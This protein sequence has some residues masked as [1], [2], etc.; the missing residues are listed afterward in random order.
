MDD[1][2]KKVCSEILNPENKEE[3]K[4]TIVEENLSQ[5]SG[6]KSNQGEDQEILINSENFKSLDKSS[7]DSSVSSLNV[8][9][10]QNAQT[11]DPSK[12]PN[13]KLPDNGIKSS[14][15]V[16]SNEKELTNDLL[17]DSNG[18]ERLKLKLFEK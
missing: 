11:N 18:T 16:E 17:K 6:S 7:T 8:E 9:D 2:C 4:A 1:N 5:L 15:E 14:T 10:D 12:E 3:A 13:K